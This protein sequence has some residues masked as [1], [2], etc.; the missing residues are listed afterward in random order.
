MAAQCHLCQLPILQDKREILSPGPCNPMTCNASLHMLPL[1]DAVEDTLSSPEQASPSLSHIWTL[2]TA[3]FPF[4]SQSRDV[5]SG[6]QCTHFL[7]SQRQVIRTFPDRHHWATFWNF[8][9]SYFKFSRAPVQVS[10][11]KGTL[12]VNLYEFSQTFRETLSALL[13]KVCHDVLCEAV[14]IFFL[15]CQQLQR[16]DQICAQALR[17]GMRFEDLGLVDT[18]TCLYGQKPV[19]LL[20]I[21]FLSTDRAPPIVAPFSPLRPTRCSLPKGN[22]CNSDTS[23]TS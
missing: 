4:V 13:T 1:R 6:L 8:Q 16:I 3:Y 5:T 14:S 9:L 2:W 7:S 17:Y 15:V 23:S 11:L 20:P 18:F 19:C 21:V 12:I 10:N 22:S